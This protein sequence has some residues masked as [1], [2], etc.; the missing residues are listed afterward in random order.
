MKKASIVLTLV[1]V[2]GFRTL[3]AGLTLSSPVF[4]NGGYIPERYSGLGKDVS[5]PLSWANVP[6]DTKSLALICDDPDAPGRTWVHWVVYALSPTLKGLPEGISRTPTLVNGAKQGTTDFGRIGY[7]GPYPPVG[8][9]HRYYFKLYAL[10]IAMTQV[11]P[12]LTKAALLERIQ[13]H[14][15]ASTELLGLFKR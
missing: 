5:P 6:P 11:G 14:V 15:L 12:G 10:D 13:G 3:G 9:P 4:M 8:K 2:I 7:G 1:L